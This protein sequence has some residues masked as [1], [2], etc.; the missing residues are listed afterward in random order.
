MKKV[1]LSMIVIAV[2]AIGISL[3]SCSSAPKTKEQIAQDSL[4]RIEEARIRAEAAVKDSS[5]TVVKERLKAI[6]A[7]DWP[8][9]YVTQKYWVNTQIECYE[10][11]LLVPDNPVKRKAQNDWP[12]DYM[13]QKFWYNQQLE[14]SKSLNE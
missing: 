13:T 10:Y 6:A 14:A 4:Q 7:R 9:D 11:M 3:N 12:N 1:I 2:S 8:N 5:L